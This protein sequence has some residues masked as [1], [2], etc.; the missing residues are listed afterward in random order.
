MCNTFF[1][2]FGYN[3]IKLV[4]KTYHID[5]PVSNVKIQFSHLD[6][7]ICLLS[8]VTCLRPYE[9]VSCSISVEIMV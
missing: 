4:F 3:S 5:L 7:I 2:C 8:M 1:F 6:T 9:V